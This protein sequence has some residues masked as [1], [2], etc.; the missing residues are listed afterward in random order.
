MS[1]TVIYS[2]ALLHKIPSWQ[3]SLATGQLGAEFTLTKFTRRRQFS[4]PYIS[5]P[6]YTHPQGYKLC[7]VVETDGDGD[8]DSD[9]DS[10]GTH[11]SIGATLMRREHDQHLQ[12]PF[13]G[14]IIFELLNWR[15]DKGHHSKKLSIQE[16]N[17]LFPV[18]DA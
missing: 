8:G 13:T 18:A 7:V 17:Y 14:D 1:D 9:C 16:D 4:C 6:F 3:G 5:P 15:E 10:E 12:W 2:T 11:L